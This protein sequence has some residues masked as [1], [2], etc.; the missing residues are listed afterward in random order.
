MSSYNTLKGF[1]QY[2]QNKKSRNPPDYV[3]KK[4]YPR[5]LQYVQKMFLRCPWLA[6]LSSVDFLAPRGCQVLKYCTRKF[7]IQIP[8]FAQSK[9]RFAGPHHLEALVPKM[10]P[11]C[12]YNI[13]LC[14]NNVSKISSIFPT[15]IFLH[16]SWTHPTCP[17]PCTPPVCTCLSTTH[18]SCLS[19]LHFCAFLSLLLPV[20]LSACLVQ[21]WPTL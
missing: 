8:N 4:M 3:P 20:C 1:S 19:L 10:S 2:A 21:I 15:D 14:L 13:Q 17:L 7:S 16:T 9:Q 12:P 18:P 6:N 5:D 11:R